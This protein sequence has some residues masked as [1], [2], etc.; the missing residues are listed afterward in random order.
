[1]HGYCYMTNHVH[2]AMQ[3]GERP[4]VLPARDQGF[5]CT[6]W[7]DRRRLPERPERTGRP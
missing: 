7:I 4:P 1:V 3:V 6:R 2:L 5:R